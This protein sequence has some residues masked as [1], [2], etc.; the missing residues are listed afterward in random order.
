MTTGNQ[1]GEGAPRKV[2]IDGPKQW[3]PVSFE[4]ARRDPDFLVLG[5]DAQGLCFRIYC[6]RYQGEK[7]FSDPC[8]LAKQTGAN[9]KSIRRLLPE[10]N[11][12]F[13]TKGDRL[14]P[15]RE[16][17]GVY[18]EDPKLP[19]IEP[20]QDRENTQVQ[21]E[22]DQEPLKD[23]QES[24][25]DDRAI[26]ES[27]SNGSKPAPPRGKWK[28]KK[29]DVEPK[30]V[31]EILGGPA[32][33]LIQAH[34]ELSAIFQQRAT[35]QIS[36]ASALARAV[37][38]GTSIDSILES[39]RTYRKSKM[40]PFTELDETR[41][42]V[43][44]HKWLGDESYRAVIHLIPLPPKK[45]NRVTIQS[46]AFNRQLE[47]LMNFNTKEDAD[48]TSKLQVSLDQDFDFPDLDGN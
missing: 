15:I 20:V 3:R 47:D 8:K 7:I 13:L 44:L 26:K 29:D 11:R 17:P 36:A 27:N 37:E 9:P 24:A 34:R 35:N 10:L 5:L 31:E 48:E 18:G 4:A 32:S 39:A 41:F 14:V 42:M 25:T 6:V 2:K 28:P 46:D 22:I 1:T 12:F 33:P 16:M 45:T 40:P 30:T 21:P 23:D 43:S 19:P 38:L